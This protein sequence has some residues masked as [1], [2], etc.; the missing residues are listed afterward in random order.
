[1]A[2]KQQ[3]AKNVNIATKFAAYPWRLTPSQIVSACK[4]VNLI[5]QSI[6]TLRTGIIK[7][8]KVVLM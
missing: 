4:Y 6:K 8:D 7:Q 5:I 3:V 1:M 2:G